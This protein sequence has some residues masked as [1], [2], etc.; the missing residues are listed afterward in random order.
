M[1]TQ[2]HT[3]ALSADTSSHGFEAGVLEF[4]GTMRAFVRRRVSNAQDAEDLSQEIMLKVFRSRASLR[5]PAKL[6]PW[7][8][9]VARAALIDYYRRKRPSE[10]VPEGLIAE[11]H[12]FDE[13]SKVLGRSARRFL[14]TLPELYRMPLELAEMQ[15]LSVADIA[16]LLKLGQSAVKSRLQRGRA[17][18]RNKMIACCRF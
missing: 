17:L 12:S 13:T 7:L 16:A 14:A 6:E 15:G 9:Q 3:P 2:Q 11:A 5:D 1:S 4:A 18:L 8:Y 10:P